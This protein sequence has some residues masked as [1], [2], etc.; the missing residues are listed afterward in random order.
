[1][2]YKE[3]RLLLAPLASAPA[4]RG[5]NIEARIRKVSLGLTVYLGGK[6][7]EDI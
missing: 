2:S 3:A 1:M 7:Q 5:N 4:S 6:K